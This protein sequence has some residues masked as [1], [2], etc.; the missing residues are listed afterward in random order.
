MEYV[1]GA[2]DFDTAVEIDN[3]PWGFRLRT[4]VRYWIET[5]NRG[6]RFVKCTLNP[7]T[8]QWCK[9]KKSTYK[10]VKVITKKVEDDKTF[11]NYTS[12]SVGWSDAVQVAN[13]EHK[14]DRT[15]LSN[16]QLKQIC[17]CKAVNEMNKNVKW[18]IKPGKTYN[19]SDPADLARMKADANS[20]EE[21]KR[22]KE[23]EDIKDKIVGYG[24]HLYNQCL[25]KNNLGG[26]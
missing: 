25:I 17:K 15:Q 20:P 12:I 1:Y 5:T 23:Q 21:L 13:F 11:I 19:L 22:K 6:D 18:E 16:K 24:N 4:K 26:K 3:Y 10:A 9:P 7:K 2:K 14:I 8:N